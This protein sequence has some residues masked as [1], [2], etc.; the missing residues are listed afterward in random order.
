MGT[1][2]NLNRQPSLAG[3]LFELLRRSGRM[4]GVT[5]ALKSC[6]VAVSSAP[7]IT[8]LLFTRLFGAGES[9]SPPLGRNILWRDRHVKGEIAYPRQVRKGDHAAG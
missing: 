7:P 8:Y 5:R 4:S 6:R 1:R 2:H 3:A 9:L